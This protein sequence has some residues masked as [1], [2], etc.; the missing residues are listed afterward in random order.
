[1][2][3]RHARVTGPAQTGG[4]EPE[5]A[6]LDPL[7]AGAH[8]LLVLPAD[9]G[10]EEVEALAVSRCDTAGWAAPGDLRLLP[11]V[12]LT[13]PWGLSEELRAG[14]DLPGWAAQAWL[15]QCP[16]HRGRPLPEELTGIDPV[17]DAFPDGVLTGVEQESVDHLRAIGR[18]LGGALR[19]AGTGA[20]VVL[21]PES[22]T[23]LTVHA[24]VWLEPAACLHLLRGVLPAARDTVEDLP[25][26]AA[27]EPLEVYAIVSEL[28]TA[29]LIEVTVSGSTHPPLVLGGEEWAQ[30]GVVAYAVRW[31]PARP[32]TAFAHR[33]PLAQRRSRAEAAARIE[34]AAAVLHEAVG[35]AIC[36]DDGF[37]VDPAGLAR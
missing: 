13:G 29:D 8:H 23:D 3:G 26:E 21:D 36:D 25:P 16:A 18:R 19:L 35:G 30:A 14:F 28:G 17:L 31:R 5:H 33:P 2:S 4:P 6:V 20:V 11:G 34:A 1:M 22:A 37:L 7:D 15:L 10:A 24:P 32:E 27:T 9:I 12:H